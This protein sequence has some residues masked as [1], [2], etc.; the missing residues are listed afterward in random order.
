MRPAALLLAALALFASPALAKPNP[1]AGATHGLANAALVAAAKAAPLKLI[2]YLEAYCDGDVTVEAWLKRLTAG[3]ARSITWSAGRCELV[4]DLNPLDAG[5]AYCAQA[6]VA[7]KHRLNRRD[8]PEIEI[9]LETP[10]HGRPGAAYAFRGMLATP[11][12]DPD[13]IRAR[14]DFEAGWRERFAH[15]PPPACQDDQ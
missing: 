13:Y 10:K 4:N 8:T 11:D 9:Y 6:V 15:A 14:R 2:D 1:A 7:L 5:G 12:G 3:E